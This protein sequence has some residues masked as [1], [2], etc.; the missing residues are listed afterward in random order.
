MQKRNLKRAKK[1]GA[2]SEHL[3]RLGRKAGDDIRAE[4]E[5]R[6]RPPRP[7]RDTNKIIGEMPPLHSLEREVVARLRRQVKMRL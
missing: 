6:T 5:T 7:L 1:I 4:R 2:A 3:A